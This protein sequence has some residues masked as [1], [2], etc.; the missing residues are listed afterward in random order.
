MKFGAWVVA[1][2]IL[3]ALGAHLLFAD[4]GYVVINI[5]GWLIE[6][7]VPILLALILATMFALWLA[8]ELFRAPKK[9]GEKA[10][11]FRAR[12]AG[13]QFTKG[14]IEVAEGNFS[15]GEKLLTRRVN[16]ADAPLLNYLAAARAEI[17]RA[18]V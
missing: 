3:G 13:H 1:T 5:R 17:G 8:W 4:P 2:L 9:L 14:L 7:S 6:M 10:G 18:H 15:K 16:R 12:R 11:E